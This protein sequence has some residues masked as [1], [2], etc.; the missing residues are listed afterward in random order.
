MRRP[1]GQGGNTPDIYIY[2]EVAN[3]FTIIRVFNYNT[4]VEWKLITVLQL[5]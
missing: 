3:P 2:Y 4:N 5:N 1:V